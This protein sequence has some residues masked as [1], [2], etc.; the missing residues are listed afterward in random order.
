M[1]SEKKGG[2]VTSSYPNHEWGPRSFT[3]LEGTVM[4]SVK[5]ASLSKKINYNLSEAVR[6]SRG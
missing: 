2:T 1:S 5:G 3:K 6:E 4:S